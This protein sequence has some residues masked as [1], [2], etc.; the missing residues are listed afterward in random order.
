[1]VDQST[2]PLV[3]ILLGPPGA[4]KGT[5]ARYLEV[6]F[7]L[8][9]LSTGDMLRSAVASG[10]DIGLRAKSIMEAGGLVGDD[11]VLAILR[12]RMLQQDLGRGIVLDGF[13]RTVSQAQ[14]LEGLLARLGMSVAAV[15]ALEAD[16][17]EM[18]QRVVGRFTCAKCGEGY[19]RQAKIPTY[20][21]TCDICGYHE[22]TTRRDDNVETVAARL[23]AYHSATAP[24]VEHFDSRGTVFR[25]DGMMPIEAVKA[26]IGKII[27]T[28][29]PSR[30]CDASA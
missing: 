17:A 4:G 11:L 10:S 29:P 8:S 26:G 6:D 15:I 16:D 7:G 22:F 30:P 24:L 25:L 27:A 2:P 9:Q 14:D 5:Q 19:H 20:P 3:I 21:G 28:L 12:D 1:M 18:I 23:A 13:P